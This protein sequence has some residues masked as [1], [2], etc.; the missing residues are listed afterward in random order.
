MNKQVVARTHAT[1]WGYYHNE[2][3][4]RNKKK[5]LEEGYKV[6]MCNTITKESGETELEYILEKESDKVE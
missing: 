3:D 5:L 6:I 1:R 4:Y 2:D